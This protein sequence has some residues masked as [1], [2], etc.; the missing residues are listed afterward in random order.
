MNTIESSRFF[1]NKAPTS[2]N[3][4]GMSF[5]IHSF[6]CEIQSQSDV[7]LTAHISDVKTVK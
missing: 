4:Q 3:F 2:P 5:K 7:N 1:V 6:V